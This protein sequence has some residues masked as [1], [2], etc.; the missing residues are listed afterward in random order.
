MDANRLI[1]IV[2]AFFLP[3]IGVLLVKGVG[4]DLLINIVLCLFF[5]VPGIIHALYV[6][7]R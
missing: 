4:K 6:V 3:P 5:Y 7:T 1:R 2:L